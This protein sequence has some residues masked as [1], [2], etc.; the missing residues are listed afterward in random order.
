M[1]K[2]ILTAIFSLSLVSQA[3]AATPDPLAEVRGIKVDLGAAATE[4]LSSG[5]NM[6]IVK[7]TAEAPSL[8]K[9]LKSMPEALLFSTLPMPGK[10]ELFNKEQQMVEVREV[11][12]MY[13]TL[14]N[15]YRIVDSL[16]F[17]KTGEGLVIVSE[18]II[19]NQELVVIKK[20]EGT[21]IG[22]AQGERAVLTSRDVGSGMATG[23]RKSMVVCQG[24]DCT[25]S[26]ELVDV[27]LLLKKFLNGKEGSRVRVSVLADI[28]GSY[29]EVLSQAAGALAVGSIRVSVNNIELLSLVVSQ[30]S[31]VSLT[32]NPPAI[33]AKGENPL[34]NSSGNAGQNPM[35]TSMKA[36]VVPTFSYAEEHQGTWRCENGTKKTSSNQ[37]C[38]TTDHF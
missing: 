24:T 19:T 21:T 10:I 20:V 17:V 29:P 6:T 12:L 3:L 1:K 34:Y 2:Q 38:G 35:H 8:I 22:I 4:K 7:K 36:L 18:R 9:V 27:R 23:R 32:Y 11:S 26:Q 16:K 25:L 13:E 37:V 14:S 5:A 33:L 15:P 28:P 30:V 31:D